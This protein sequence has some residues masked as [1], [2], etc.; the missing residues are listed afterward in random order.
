MDPFMILKLSIDIAAFNW[1][2]VKV[3]KIM[4]CAPELASRTRLL[5]SLRA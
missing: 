5:I 4:R 2:A 3:Q 1:F